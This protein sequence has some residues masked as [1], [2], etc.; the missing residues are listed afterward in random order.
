MKMQSLRHLLLLASLVPA[1][2]GLWS[3]AEVHSQPL[4]CLQGQNHIPIDMG[5]PDA[6]GVVRPDTLS[7]PAEKHGYYFSVPTRSAASL[8]VGDQ[9]FDLDMYLYVRGKCPQGS[10]EKLVRTWSARSE[11]M[12]LQFERPDEQ[13]I[14]L[15]PGDYLLVIGH[16]YAEDPEYARDFDPSRGFTVRIALNPPYCGL[17]P[18]D[19]LEPNPLDPSVMMLRRPDDALYQLGLNFQPDEKELG[20]FS[21]MTFNAFVSPPYTDLYDFK[22]ELDGVALPGETT[23]IVQTATTDLPKTSDGKHKVRVTAIGAREYPDPFLSHIPPTLAVEC[24]FKIG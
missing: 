18:A 13:I 3:P 7:N 24:T 4:E 23:P 10:W 22:W 11:R 19:V 1:L 14:N 6:Q 8:Y 20:P 9:W 21:L 5:T 12:V 2:V 15:D 16:K 17:S